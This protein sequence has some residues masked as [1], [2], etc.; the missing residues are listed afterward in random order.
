MTAPRD[1][2]V[3][4]RPWPNGYIAI[5]LVHCDAFPDLSVNQALIHSP[6]VKLD[7]R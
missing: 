3:Y 5:V 1:P 4:L 6:L 2:A 7:P